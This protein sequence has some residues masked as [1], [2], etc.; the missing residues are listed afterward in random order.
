VPG[1]TTM[2]WIRPT[3]SDSRL[4]NRGY[5]PDEPV[6]PLPAKCKA[7]GFPDLDYVPQPY[8][9][10]RARTRCADEMVLAEN[11]NFL[12]RA[13]ARRI[14]E[15]AVS[16]E[17]AFYPTCCEKSDE[18]TQWC[19]AVPQSLCKAGEVS[20][21]I[22]RCP[23]CGEPAS[24]HPGTQ[25]KEYRAAYPPEAI[26]PHDPSGHDVL[27]ALN[28]QSSERS[29]S[30]WVDRQR[31]LSVRLLALLT[32]MAVHGIVE[33]L[34][35]TA[36][37]PVEL[38]WVERKMALLAKRGVPDHPPGGVSQEDKRWYGGFLKAHAVKLRQPPDVRAV[39]KKHKVKFPPSY[40]LFARKVGKMTFPDADGRAGEAVTVLPPHKCDCRSYRRGAIE[41]DGGG[42][43]IDGVMFA[44]TDFGDCFCFALEKGRQEPAV[45]RY[46][47]EGAFFEAYTDNFIQCMRRFCGE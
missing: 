17:F 22:P 1:V 45:F 38:K 4:D 30:V 15:I 6:N 11:G 16:G 27:K 2:R 14:L 8:R 10:I 39:E 7:C 23:T 32:R 42:P 33:V 5:L 43:D 37:S 18:P 40:K 41:L 47:H 46:L 3:G 19:L 35:D 20:D 44:G 26:G 9:L 31:L 21:E 25:Y 29:W 34:E 24:A 13:R 36:P 28:W 12:V